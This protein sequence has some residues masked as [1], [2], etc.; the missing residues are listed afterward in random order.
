MSRIGKIP[1]EVPKNVTIDIKGNIFTCSG[2]LGKTSKKIH[3]GINVKVENSLV[4]LSVRDNDEKY[5]K[6]KGL[7]RTI[8]SNI[9]NG[10]VSGFSKELE[11]IGIGYRAEMKGKNL[12]L[13]LGYSHPIN[14]AV[15]E[16]ITIS[17]EKNTLLKIK[18]YDKELVGLVASRIRGLR[19][20][21]PYKGKG[22]KYADEVIRRK[23]G[24]AAGK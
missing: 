3:E 17:V 2:P 18:G 7:T 22:I 16:G 9:I 10:V 1:V 13:N 11:I 12:I 5:E 6:F 15:P 4:S 14:F 8:I 24:K 21:E 20:P 23:V 19:K